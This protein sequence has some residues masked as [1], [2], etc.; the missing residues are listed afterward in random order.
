MTPLSDLNAVSPWLIQ[1]AGPQD[2]V[3]KPF[4]AQGTVPEWGYLIESEAPLNEVAKHYRLLSVVLTPLKIPMLLRVADPAVAAAILPDDISPATAPWGPIQ[5]LHLPDAVKGSWQSHT[6]QHPAS[7]PLTIDAGGYPLN[8][9]Q[10]Q[11]L[12]TCNRRRDIRHLMGFVNQYHGDWLAA[13][14]DLQRFRLLAL[15]VEDARHVGFTSPKEW[16]LLCTLMA[17]LNLHS[18]QALEEHS[19]Y[20]MLLGSRDSASQRL[21]QALAVTSPKAGSPKTAAAAIEE[22]NDVRV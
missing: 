2:K 21:K 20:P 13:G 6:P 4:L 16:A 12:Q 17:R 10:H 3:L 22:A 19:V 15:L 9:D 5:Q 7:A 11:R 14:S 1:L 8:E 18:W